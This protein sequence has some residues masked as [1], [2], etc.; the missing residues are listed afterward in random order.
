MNRIDHTAL[1][2]Q[3][4]LQNIDVAADILVLEKYIFLKK[5]INQ[6]NIQKITFLDIGVDKI[7]AMNYFL[8]ILFLDLFS[9]EPGEI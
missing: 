1:E 8:I 5:I 2:K 6:I 9:G 7:H 4:C 3:M